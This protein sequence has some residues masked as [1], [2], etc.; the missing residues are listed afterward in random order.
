MLDEPR[1]VR[2]KQHPGVGGTGSWRHGSLVELLSAVPYLFNSQIFPG[3]DFGEVDIVPPVSVVNSLLCTGRSDAG[4]S[5]G[6]EWE[7]FEIDVSEYQHLCEELLTLPGYRFK[8]T[9]DSERD[10]TYEQWNALRL[11]WA[12]ERRKAA[13]LEAE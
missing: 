4:M 12:I 8:V 10:L 2:F 13:N 1:V 11:E 6:A 9:A 5:G 3:Q 7:P